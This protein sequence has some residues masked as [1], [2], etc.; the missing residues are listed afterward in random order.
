VKHNQRAVYIGEAR[1]D[2]MRCALLCSCVPNQR[3]TD[4]SFCCSVSQEGDLTSNGNS[5]MSFNKSWKSC[6]I[7]SW[8]GGTKM[9][10]MPGATPNKLVQSKLSTLLADVEPSLVALAERAWGVLCAHPQAGAAATR[11]LE[12]LRGGCGGRA[13]AA[14]GRTG[15]NAYSFN[16]D[17]ATAAHYDSKNVSG[18]YSCLLIYETGAP[19]CGS[20]YMLPQFRTALDVRQGVALFHRSGDAEVGMHA[21]S[22]CVALHACVAEHTLSTLADVAPHF[23]RCASTQAVLPG[24]GEPP[25]R[26][27]A[28]PD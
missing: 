26:G 6:C 16:L 3:E 27:R 19:F 28:I 7:R 21:N 22:G 20:Y 5:I 2:A 13:R 18:S 23:P 4:P 24:A 8:S 12:Y 15:W 17:Y 25:H 10:D 1:T 14:L 9:A 11:Q